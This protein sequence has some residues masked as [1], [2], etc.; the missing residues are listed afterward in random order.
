M[1]TA[2]KAADDH[3]ELRSLIGLLKLASLINRPMLENVA[4]PESLSLNELRVMM[5]LAG[6]GRAAAHDLVVVLGMHPMAVS[7]AV[8]ALREDGRI[9]EARD[10]E[11]RRRKVLALTDAGW[12][13]HGAML[14]KAEQVA[15]RLFSALSD[16]ERRTIRGLLEKLTARLEDWPGDAA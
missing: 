16:G 2:R 14:P 13:A 11:N 12:A 3:L 9:V 5:S 15:T 7:R 8:S 6:E 1:T 10:P 4:A